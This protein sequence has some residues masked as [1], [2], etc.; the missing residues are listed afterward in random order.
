MLYFFYVFKEEK[1][2]ILGKTSLDRS[3]LRL[4]DW[5]QNQN[6]TCLY[7]VTVILTTFCFICHSILFYWKK[8]YISSFCWLENN[9][10]FH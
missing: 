3:F 2:K 9:D 8:L 5:Y 4:I 10:K 7:N 1:H 6:R